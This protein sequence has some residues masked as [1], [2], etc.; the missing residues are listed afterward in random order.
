LEGIRVIE[1]GQLLAV[2]YLCKL[3]ADMGAEIVRFESCTRLDPHRTTVFYDNEADE[4]FYNKAAN[5][6]DQNRNKLGLTLDLSTKGGQRMFHD[7]VRISDVFCEN[8]TPRVMQ[9]FQM[10]YQNLRR[11]RP[12]IIMLSSTGYG[13]TG[14]WGNYGAVGPTVEASSGLM[15]VSGYPG[16]PPVLAEIPYTDFVGAEHGLFAVMAAL[17]YRARTGHGQFIDLSQQASQVAIAPEPVLDY[18]TNGRDTPSGGSTDH[19]TMAPYGAFPCQPERQTPGRGEIDRWIAIAVKTDQE[20]EGL[21]RVIGD[22]AL[23]SDHR[24][25]DAASRWRYRKELNE[26]IAEWTQSQ[27]AFTLMRRLQSQGV[28]AGVAL[29]NRD[30]LFEPHLKERGFFRVIKHPEGSELPTIPYPGIPWRLREAPP[31]PARAGASLGEHNRQII[32]EL[33]GWPEGD[34]ASL[35]QEGAIGWEPVSYPRPNPV[36]VDV[37]LR[38]SRIAAYDQDFKERIAREYGGQKL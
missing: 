8:F 6:H 24:F 16:T 2:P 25:A 23:S 33:L 4:Q 20:W 29:T 38:Q 7:L 14:P 26:R 35:Q 31:L 27:E 28:P 19:P 32:V 10:E 3:M 37:L 13:Y 9:N 5:F 36:G 18:L 22:T 12:D 11:I 30:M 15:H 17:H 34:L 1:M 21:L